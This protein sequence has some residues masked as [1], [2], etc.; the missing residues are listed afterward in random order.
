MY[1]LNESAGPYVD[2]TTNSNNSTTGI[3][4]TKV[5]GQVGSGES[6]NGSTNYIGIPD[7][8]VLDV[9]N[10]ATISAWFKLNATGQADIL[11]KGGNNGYVL[12]LD[13]TQIAFG[14]QNTTVASF[15]Y[16][17]TTFTTGV[18]YKIDGVNN[19]GTK[20]IYV[21]GV[22]EGTSSATNSFSNTGVL[23][24]GN[25]LDGFFNGIN[26]DVNIDSTA[27]SASWIATE[28]NNQK[29][30]GTFYGLAAQEALNHA[31]AGTAKTVSGTEETAYTFTASDFGFSDTN[32][33]PVNSLS[34]V[35]ITTLPGLGSL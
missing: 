29:T 9:T 30:P 13:G 4:P 5:T 19:A 25:G 14:S 34:S 10:N 31:P 11:E 20:S 6:F 3:A 24:I 35:K 22:L 1:H 33:S 21:N 12:W 2:V 18:W 28:Y 26:D 17:T 7:A 23:Q 15:A 27:R 8:A 32:N 16:T